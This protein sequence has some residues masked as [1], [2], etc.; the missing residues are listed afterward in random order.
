MGKV[1]DLE[2]A[3]QARGKMGPKGGRKPAAEGGPEPAMGRQRCP[4]CRKP[5]VQRFRPFCSARCADIDLGR[6]IGGHYR[7]PGAP[8]NTLNSEDEGGGED[9]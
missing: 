7:V 3:R 2:K 9:G 6:W 5:A 4:I 1:E 8:A